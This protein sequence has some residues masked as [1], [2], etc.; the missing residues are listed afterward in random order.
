MGWL[1]ALAVL[2]AVGLIPLGGFVR[3]D[4]GG[5]L[6]KVVAGFLRFKVY[7]L[8]K[9][10]KAEP[11]KA[12]KQK[13]PS[14]SKEAKAPPKDKPEEQKGGSLRDFYPLIQLG[15]RFLNHFRRKLRINHLV[16]KITLGG[17]DPC[18]L[19]VNYGRTWAAL[20]NLVPTL[21]RYFRIRQR[22][23][24]VQCDFT[25]Q[26]TLLEA[27]AE[28]TLRVYELIHMGIVYGYLFIKEFLQ[29]KKKRKGGAVS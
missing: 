17:E 16:L 23:F 12:E 2:I 21:E 22:N 1:I 6:V 18:D 27:Q 8:P 24:E 26:E 7:P 11:K 9:R 19:A 3:Y 25:A 28:L 15:L 29:L 14:K 20:A 13:K 4:S 10:K 5:L